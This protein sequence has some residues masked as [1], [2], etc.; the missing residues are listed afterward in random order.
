MNTAQATAINPETLMRVRGYSHGF[1]A[2][3]GWLFIAGQLGTDVDFT[4]PGGDDLGQQFD[5]ALW[6]LLEVVR[7]AGGEPINVMKMT[8]F[9]TD[10]D[11]WFARQDDLG[12]VY[13][14]HFGRHYPAI[15]LLAQPRLTIPGGKV[16]IEGI[17]LV[18]GREGNAH[19]C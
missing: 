6:N 7:R 15:T 19:G 18:P 14:R 13:R 9:V 5:R 4:Y 1:L 12:P 16:E 8:F 17:A 11:E 2:P 3:G 10:L